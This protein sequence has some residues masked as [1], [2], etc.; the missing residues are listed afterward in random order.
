MSNILTPLSL[1]K[2]FDD[3]QPLIDSVCDLV[4]RDGITY[5]S[6]RF[7]GRSTGVGRVV[8]HGV[9][10]YSRENPSNN[11][12]LIIPDSSETVDENLLELFVKNGYS[13]LMV[14]IRGR[15]DG[16]E[17]YT[18]YPSDVEYANYA[19][20]KTNL[21]SVDDS[22]DK[23]SWYEWVAVGLYS[24]K[25][26]KSRM[27]GGKVG[28][29]GIRDGGEV[30]WK[31]AFAGDFACAVPV[32]AGGWRSYM[33]YSKFGGG[34]PD[35]DEGKRRFMAAIDSQ[36]YAPYVK[37]PILMLC[38]TN[39]P[40]FDYDRAY[41]TFSR[42]NPQVVNQSVIAYSIKSNACIGMKSVKDMFMFLDKHVKD[43][44]V[45]ISKPAEL[46]VG[47]DDDSNL[48]ARIKIDDAG[49]VAQ[50]GVFMAEDCINPTTRDWM[51]ARPVKN[52]DDNRE[53]YL[54]IYEKTN[55][56]FAICFVTYSNGFT[57]WSKITVKKLSGAFRN[58][59]LKSRVMYSVRNGVDCFSLADYANYSIAKTFFAGEDFFPKIIECGDEK[60]KGLYSPCGLSTY[61]LNSP[62]FMPAADSI[63]KF[64]IY[65][66]NDCVLDIIMASVHNDDKFFVKIGLVGGMWQSIVLDSKSFKSVD[67]RALD[68]FLGG[69]SLTIKCPSEYAVNN[70]MW[71]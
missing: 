29:V 49:E 21:T 60:L 27:N 5:E 19:Q 41:D 3:N 32:C 64:D 35:F 38:S 46:V 16:V 66:S 42:I 53:F 13:A 36:S 33:G 2:N 26:L 25:Y 7:Y 43:R 23:T 30:A 10:A 12:V 15:W 63:L 56:L 51:R 8:V 61:R 62:M 24:C 22:A 34:E 65:V 58:S 28:L 6:V 1:W 57:V 4:T 45:F 31:L 47:L 20:A 50:V 69:F 54:D 44:Q 59:Q 17:N 18:V 48:I 14:D 55:I 68:N 71:L 70:V 9:F 40:A 11:G 37:C 52:S 67:G 39:D